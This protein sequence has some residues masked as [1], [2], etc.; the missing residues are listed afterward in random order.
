[1]KKGS[2]KNLSDCGTTNQKITVHGVSGNALGVYFNGGAI[3]ACQ[4][5][6]NAVGNFYKLTPNAKSPYISLY[7]QN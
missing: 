1:M 4:T 3:E 6:Q 2:F 5:A 7:T